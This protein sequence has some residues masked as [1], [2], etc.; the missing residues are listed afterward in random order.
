MDTRLR[1]QP[2][3]LR[4]PP[5][6]ALNRPF[7]DGCAEG[8]LR[9]VRCRSCGTPDFPAAPF[10]RTCQS[11]DLRWE[12]GAGL[13]TIYSWTVVRRP[14]TPDLVTPYA[15]CIVELDEGYSMLTNVVDADV[16]EI[17]VGLRVRVVFHAVGD[18]RTLPCFTPI[19]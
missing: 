16:T 1:P 11:E 19:R 6:S 2:G 12:T 8:E 5:P 18:E 15:P 9:F 3:P 13:G 4:L 14:A 17:A 10:C 7:W